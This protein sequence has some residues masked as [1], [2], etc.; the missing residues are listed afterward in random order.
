MYVV[1]QVQSH[2]FWAQ[3]GLVALVTL[4]EAKMQPDEGFW[5]LVLI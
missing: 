3:K 1:L 2:T 4:P 5:K